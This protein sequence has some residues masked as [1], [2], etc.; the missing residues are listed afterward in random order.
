MFLTLSVFAWLPY[1]ASFLLWSKQPVKG[2]GLFHHI[3]VLHEGNSGL[4]TQARTWRKKLNRRPWSDA[5]CWLAPPGLF[6]VLFHTRKINQ[7]MNKIY[8]L[9]YHLAI[10]IY[11]LS[12]VIY[13]SFIYL[14]IYLTHIF[15][16]W[17]CSFSPEQFRN[18][19]F[20]KHTARIK[21]I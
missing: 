14:P 2:K 10:T 16:V 9:I 19:L 18:I 4:K 21:D 3:S 12:S 7:S 8:W 1:I 20:R 11:Q 5:A 15:F 13:S 6:N 17:A